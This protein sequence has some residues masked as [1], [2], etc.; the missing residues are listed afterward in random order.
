MVF[1]SVWSVLSTFPFCLLMVTQTS[2]PSLVIASPR[3][4]C[5]GCWVRWWFCYVQPSTFCF[6][7]HR[8]YNIYYNY[9]IKVLLPPKIEFKFL[10]GEVYVWV[11]T[12]LPLC[13][14][15]EH[16]SWHMED[17]WQTLVECM[18]EGRSEWLT[19]STFCLCG[20]HRS[21]LCSKRLQRPTPLL[22]R[23]PAAY[24]CLYLLPCEVGPKVMLQL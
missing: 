19:A 16:S 3:K 8:T 18:I 17:I 10:E 9:W 15:P 22:T 11:S 14:Q 24:N 13:F 12:G 5:A 2:H 6:Y 1:F 7:Y 20:L 23:P 4:P 21:V